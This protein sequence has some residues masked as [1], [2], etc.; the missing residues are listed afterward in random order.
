VVRFGEPLAVGRQADADA[1]ERARKTL[2]S[3][4]ATVSS[5]ADLE[6]AA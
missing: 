5:A 1:R 6:A 2:E 3:A 4:L